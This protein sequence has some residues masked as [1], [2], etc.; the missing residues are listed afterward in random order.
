M[1]LT[2]SESIDK[3]LSRLFNAA[4]IIGLMLI[5]VGFSGTLL[6]YSHR[7]FT[8]ELSSVANVIASASRAAL[9]FG[10]QKAGDRILAGLSAKPS[11]AYA[12]LID[13]HGELLSERG[14]PPAEE[15]KIPAVED[16]SII[17]RWTYVTLFV[18]VVVDNERV[19][20]LAV[21][22][23]L[24][25]FYEQLR[26]F[27]VITFVITLIAASGALYFNS[28]LR[29]LVV[30]PVL[31]LRDLAREV[32][33][34]KDF[35]TRLP[36]PADT[37]DEVSQLIRT[38]NQMLGQLEERDRALVLEKNKAEEAD[39]LKTVFL[40][41]VSHELRTPLHAILGMTDELVHTELSQ[42]QRE[43]L[44]VVKHSGSLL[45]SIINDILDF[46]KI[47]AGKLILAPSR[48]DLAEFLNR[49]V[50]MFELAAKKK[51]IQI[52]CTTSDDAPTVLFADSGRLAQ[53]FVNLL[54]NAL[55]FT[56]RGS[57][58][59]HVAPKPNAANPEIPS[60]QFTV[61]D[62]GIGIPPE[63]L[64]HIF[65][66]F[67]QAHDPNQQKD[68][69]GL[70]LAISS[71]L[72]NMM[73]GTIWAE[74]EV[75]TG[76]CFHFVLPGTRASIA[77]EMSSFAR[78]AMDV[79]SRAD[80]KTDGS[81]EFH[82]PKNTYSVLVVEDNEVNSKLALR[83]LSKAG[84]RVLLAAN[85]Q[86]GLDVLEREKVDI[87][88]MDMN[89]PVMDGLTAARLIREREQTTNHRVSIIALTANA[90]DDQAELCAEI[91]MDE[92]LTKPL[93]RKTLLS[94]LARHLPK[95]AST[96]QPEARDRPTRSPN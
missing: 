30:D 75:G 96:R 9:I 13:S 80:T 41:T 91:G 29:H 28:L 84:Y 38:F 70:G 59:I 49:I 36:L 52:T 87:V 50:Q 58:A 71:K 18:P 14:T 55:K 16:E 45:I 77:D 68:G 37:H 65:E 79:P 67:T 17:W 24:D 82:V 6:Y 76:S 7:T 72:V 22:S 85:G 92:F 3:R 32:S 61:T 74:S 48:F 56:Q 90:M 33:L 10:D 95:G 23:G 81:A 42:E 63:Y 31:S 54:G 64:Q 15:T 19:G 73:G 40:T 60:V 11:I 26:L 2:R 69:T 1:K 83:V 78:V 46:S 4:M 86:E 34:T 27:L 39:R 57:I 53:I 51:G 20:T 8:Q 89:M 66:S 47:E 93:D 43:L 88:L 12:A 21:I 62:T 25:T 5:S 94:V 44:G 35:S